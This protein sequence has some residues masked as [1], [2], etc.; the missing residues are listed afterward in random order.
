MLIWVCAM[1][2]EAKPV[3]DYYRLKKSYDDNAYDLYRGADMICIVSGPG[4]LA[5]AAATA[6]IAAYEQTAGSLAWINLGIAGA[7]DHD[8]GS[9]FLLHQIID[10]DSDQRFYPLMTEKP[11]IIGTTA[12]CLS[13]PSTEYHEAYL[14]DMESSGFMQSA[15]CFSSAELVRCIKVISDNRQSQTGRNRQAVSDLIAQ[16]LAA[17]DAQAQTL[18]ELNRQLLDREI[19]ADTWKQFLALAHFS[20]TEKNRLR[21]L[22][23]YLLNRRLQSDE[24]LNKLGEQS[25]ATAILQ[26]LEAMSH[27]D[28]ERL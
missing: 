13:Q 1:H 27:Q 25:S 6:W 26:S 3:I 8:I 17:I 14:F 21:V 5:S 4:K 16:H 18:I 24:L 9:L 12:L 7:A 2:C 19:T 10:A 20:Q 11:A 15:L 22:L 23:R 28:S